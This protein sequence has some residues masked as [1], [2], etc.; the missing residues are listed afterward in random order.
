MFS[1]KSITKRFSVFGRL[2]KLGR[3]FADGRYPPPCSA[4]IEQEADHLPARARLHL[5]RKAD[6][7]FLQ[8]GGEKPDILADAVL[9]NGEV[10]VRS[11]M[12]FPSSSVTARPRDHVDARLDVGP[13]ARVLPETERHRKKSPAPHSDA[14]RRP[15]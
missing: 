13:A 4:G 1:S 9:E 5:G 14:N 6:P 12:K 7:G 10:F 3:G 11:V 15:G 8:A 2:V